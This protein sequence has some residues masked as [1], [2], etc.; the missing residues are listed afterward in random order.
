MKELKHAKEI[1]KRSR[2]EQISAKV[3]MK[4]ARN[5]VQC[6]FAGGTGGFVCPDAYCGKACIPKAGWKSTR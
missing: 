1:A 4:R 5:A 2:E 3:E 6:S